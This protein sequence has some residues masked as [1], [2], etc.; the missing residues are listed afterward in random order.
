M[1]VVPLHDRDDAQAAVNLL[2]RAAALLPSD[3]PA[4]ARLYTGLGTALTEV[5][6]LE[7]ARAT[8]DQAQ[9]IA[10]V[11]G[12][13]G[14][15]AHARVQALLLGLKLAPNRAARDR[16]LAPRIA[17]PVWPG[18]DEVGLCQTLR[19]EAAVYWI[20][21]RSAAAEEA[22]RR[23]AEYARQ[24]NDR[25]ELTEI[26]GWL[27]SAALWGPTPASEGYSAVRT[28]SVRSGT[29]PADRL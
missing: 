3:D 19:L 12:D 2:T 16:S 11:D 25:S 24:T 27:A 17:Q 26:L 4:L 28:I 5:G 13:E 23:A 22:W 10:A 21:G 1:P 15:R 20:H 9:R 7:K 14:Q 29:I 18:P 6:Q 8:L